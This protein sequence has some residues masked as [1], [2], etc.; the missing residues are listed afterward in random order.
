MCFVVETEHIPSIF[1]LLFCS[2]F[3]K[4]LVVTIFF[5]IA[6]SSCGLL[7]EVFNI[8]CGSGVE[9]TEKGRLGQ[10]KG[11]PEL[12]RRGSNIQCWLLRLH[13]VGM[14]PVLILNRPTQHHFPDSFC[15]DSLLGETLLALCPGICSLG[16]VFCLK[17]WC[18]DLSG[19]V[20][21][22]IFLT[23]LVASMCTVIVLEELDSFVL[24]SGLVRNNSKEALLQFLKM[25]VIEISNI[26]EVKWEWWGKR[27]L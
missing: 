26:S 11:T 19:A 14:W 9:F 20:K 13:T 18:V 25:V 24:F 10:E 6:Y 2:L 12:W 15:S 23:S 21:R 16:S 27:M 4:I 5:L 22:R 7:I 8:Y 1:W 17:L 3:L